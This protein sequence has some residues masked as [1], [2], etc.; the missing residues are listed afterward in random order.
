MCTTSPRSSARCAPRRR[1]C[2]RAR[3]PRARSSGGSPPDDSCGSTRRMV[4]LA[5]A[6]PTTGSCALTA[7]GHHRDA[8][9]TRA[10]SSR[11]GS[12]EPGRSGSTSPCGS[13]T[14]SVHPSAR[15]HAQ[16]APLRGHH[17][18]RWRDDG[19]AGARRHVGDAHRGLGTAATSTCPQCAAPGG[20]NARPPRRTSR[21]SSPRFAAAGVASLRELPGGRPPA[22]QPR[23]SGSRAAR[24]G[25]PGRSCSTAVHRSVG[26]VHVD[27]AWPEVKLAVEFDGAAFHGDREARQRD[28]RRD[29]ALAALGWV[30]LRFSYRRRH[31]RPQACGPRSRPRTGNAQDVPSLPFERRMA[32][33]GHRGRP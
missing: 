1:P 10:R 25:L 5:R 29:A 19:R 33:R 31:R 27:A 2:W 23:S 12:T 18:A 9:T 8:V 20:R 14:A 21:P 3:R 7:T 28:L 6:G 24:C 32:P 11:R 26:P 16:P 4:T 30:V 22:V 15:S 17:R 13:V